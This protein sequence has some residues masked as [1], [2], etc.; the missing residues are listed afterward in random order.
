MPFWWR[1]RKRFW[2]GRRR[3]YYKRTYKTKYRRRRRRPRYRRPY[4]RRRRSR[5]KVRRKLKKLKLVQWQPDTIRKCK[6]KGIT[7]TCLGGHGKQY[8]CFTDSRFEWVPPTAPGG[9]GFGCEQ[10]SL[11]YLFKEFKRGNNKWSVS[12][13]F[14]DL[15]RYTG[16]T[17]RFYRHRFIDFLV[18]YNLQYPF[19]FDKFTYPLCHPY[20]IIQ[21]K[22]H[23]VIPSW[24]TLPRGRRYVK[25]K[26]KPPKQLT[27]AWHFQHTFAE[28]PLLQLNTSA[29]DLNFSFLGCCNTNRLIT[30]YSLNTDLYAKNGWGNPSLWGTH[31]YQPYSQAPTSQNINFKGQTLYGQTLTGT[32]NVTD[33]KQSITYENGWFQKNLL[34]IAQ[35]TQDST[36]QQLNIPIAAGR[37]NPELDTGEGNAIWLVDI[38]STQYVKPSHDKTIILEGIPLW[39]AMYGF[40]D[41]VEKTKGTQSFLTT[42]LLVIESPAIQPKLA[43]GKF[44]IPIDRTFIMGQGPYK[45][46]VT[47]TDKAHWFPSL[48]H[49]Q[50]TMNAFV[51]TGP[52]I[53]KLE[54]IKD[55]T[56]ELKAGYTFY[57]KWGGSQFPDAEAF[58]PSKQDTYAPPGNLTEDIQISDPKTQIPTN[59]LHTW[60]FRRGFVTGKAL[61]R[62]LQDQTTASSIQ[63]DAETPSPK[64]RKYGENTLQMQTKESKKIQKCLQKIF[65][66]SSSQDS[67][68]IPNLQQLIKQQK[69]KQQQ[70]K[71]QLMELLSNL[72][73]KQQAL[74]LH[75]GVLD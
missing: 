29:A 48:Q 60:D 45:E 22:H 26:I 16:C 33:Y 3:P 53:P 50:E 63:T 6:I 39:K 35:F 11:N 41:Y 17:F 74:Q 8:R 75:T 9:G 69:H 58:D 72:K 23:K 13:D 21:H 15:V 43:S 54:N 25:V 12:N 4:R 46:Y 1:R 27:S 65:E 14:L 68:E 37:Y 64:R 57:F 73:S 55:S 18:E 71:L 40:T 59:I 61:K 24:K 52:L 67:E 30:F 62:I 19:T 2:R 28:K 66:E 42:A 32:I 31:G 34:Q 10:F 36:Y 51:Q 20:E 44:W 70:L 7:V 47:K 56:W 38:L 5:K 49:Q